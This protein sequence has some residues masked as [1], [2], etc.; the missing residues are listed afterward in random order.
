MTRSTFV[1]GLVAVLACLAPVANAQSFQMDTDPFQAGIQNSLTV[2]QGD[3]FEVH[4]VATNVNNLLGWSADV[5]FDP[6]LLELQD[7]K[8]NPGDLDFDSKLQFS[9]LNQAIGFYVENAQTHDPDWP[10]TDLNSNECFVD[11]SGNKSG[12]LLDLDGDNFLS[13]KELNR[14]IGE[15]V[16]DVK[17]P[18]GTTQRVVYWTDKIFGRAGFDYNESV[19]VADPPSFSNTGGDN[20]GIVKDLVG[21]LLARPEV[22]QSGVRTDFGFDTDTLGDAVL[23]TLSFE[24]L[25]A[26]Q[27]TIG[28]D[29][30]V[31]I[32][33]AFQDVDTDVIPV[34]STSDATITI[35]E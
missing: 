18:D 30:A 13:F 8:A 19:S 27:A 29:N 16:D 28:F 3:Q 9:E 26:G 17:D 11:D 24:A 33:E 21:V 6:A 34:A 14:V 25:A 10:L 35:T 20:E 15:Y 7:S 4:I 23:M 12:V 22:V 32:N 2:A 5:V 1:L 31:Y